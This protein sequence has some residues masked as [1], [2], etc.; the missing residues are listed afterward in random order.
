VTTVI[1]VKSARLRSIR[2]AYRKSCQSGFIRLPPKL[3][4]ETWSLQSM[5]DQDDGAIHFQ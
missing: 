1:S 3:N 5:P 2:A 4:G